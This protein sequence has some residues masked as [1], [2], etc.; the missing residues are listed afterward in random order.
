MTHFRSVGFGLLIGAWVFT[1][2]GCGDSTPSDA[3]SEAK[4]PESASSDPAQPEAPNTE[5]PARMGSAS[6]TERPLVYEKGG[7]KWIGEVPIDVWFD[8]PLAVATTAGEVAPAPSADPP[9]APQVVQTETQPMPMPMPMPETNAGG[10]DWKRVIPGD[11]LDAEVTTI[12]NRFAADL[13]TVGSYNSS[14]LGLPPHAVTLAALSHIAEKHPDDIRWKKNAGYIKHLA[15]QMNAEPLRTGPSSHRPLKEKFDYIVEILSGSVPATIEA[16]PEDE[17]IQDVAKV[18]LIMKR[19]ENA[20]KFIT[21]NGGTADAM[22][23]NADQLKQE[24]AVLGALTQVLLD[25]Y[26]DYQDDDVFEGYVKNM[27]EA[28]VNMREH[29]QSEQFDKFELDV[30]RM[31]Q[32]CQQCHSDYR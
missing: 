15:G 25:G 13:Q 19:L 16:P 21:V 17:S 30:S 2:S 14:H 11:L 10:I 3:N 32:S 27:V 26:E 4:T 22:K 8:D 5:D 18:N 6:P 20:S 12:R 9:Q 31:N 1:A 29:I 24:A 23:S 7:K 28:T